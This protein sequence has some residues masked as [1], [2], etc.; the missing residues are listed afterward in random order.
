MYT[1]K[2]IK[3]KFEIISFETSINNVKLNLGKKS[4]IINNQTIIDNLYLNKINPIIQ[5]QAKNI[6][7]YL[8]TEEDDEEKTGLLLDD[9]SRQRGIILKKYEKLMSQEARLVYMKNI[10]FLANSLNKRLKTYTN[11]KTTA[12]TRW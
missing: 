9:L 8:N 10:R 7:I 12:K 4:I 2:K 6:L 5:K 11:E 3:N 1:I